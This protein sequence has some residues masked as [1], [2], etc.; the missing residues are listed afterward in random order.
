MRKQTVVPVKVSSIDHRIETTIV[1]D[2]CRKESF[3]DGEVKFGGCVHGGWLSVNRRISVSG[4]CLGIPSNWD[5]CSDNC[6]IEHF[7]KDKK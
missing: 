7:T 2:E 3:D 6:M 5:F 1:C 4:S